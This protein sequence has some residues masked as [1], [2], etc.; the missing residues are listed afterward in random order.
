[1]TGIIVQSKEIVS[2]LGGGAASRDDLETLRS[3]GTALVAADGGADRAL[4]LGWMPQAVIGDLDSLSVTA[5][6][7]LPEEIVYPVA[8]QDSTDFEKCLRRISAPLILGAGFLGDRLDHQLACF[9]AMLVVPH[10]PVILIDRE[11]VVFLC[12]PVIALDVAAGTRASLFPMRR[13]SARS[14]GL[15]WPLDGLDLAPDRVIST[16]NETSQRGLEVRC[17]TPGLMVILP[18]QALDA[19]VQ[20]FCAPQTGRWPAPAG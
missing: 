9:H 19:A 16:S 4:S 12:P 8:E 17:D 6:S 5:R 11:Q 14:K 7:T 20:A 13:V 2:L 10:K 1:M 18:R 15:R 3:R